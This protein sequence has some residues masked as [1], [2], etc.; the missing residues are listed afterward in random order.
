MMMGSR[1]QL[2]RLKSSW[3]GW[4]SRPRSSARRAVPT[5]RRLWMATHVPTGVPCTPR[6]RRLRG[7]LRS[8]CEQPTAAATRARR[9][10]AEGRRR[11]RPAERRACAARCAAP[12]PGPPG[13]SRLLLASKRCAPIARMLVGTPSASSANPC[14][15]S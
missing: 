8:D 3:G 7:T 9:L 14:A 4:L 12:A 5:T 15:A 13:R 2:Y 10:C 6:A 11:A 1:C